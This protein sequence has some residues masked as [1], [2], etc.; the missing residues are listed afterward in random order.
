M[1]KMIRMTAQE[2]NNYKK[3]HA[4][5]LQ[6]AY[7]A[8]E[9]VLLENDDNLPVNRIAR[10]FAEFKEYINKNGRPKVED[11]KVSISIRIPLSYAEKLRAT[12]RGWQTRLSEYMVAGIKKGE[13]GNIKSEK[14]ALNPQ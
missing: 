8:A 2:M 1:K 4:A 13:L 3:K 14:T 11:P 9:P 10:G 7:D 6:A 5:E 12:G